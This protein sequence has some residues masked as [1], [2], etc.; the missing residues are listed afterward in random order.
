VDLLNL[1]IFLMSILLDMY[2]HNTREHS[3]GLFL[4][5]CPFYHSH[6]PG[7]SS[8]A[9]SSCQFLTHCDIIANHDWLVPMYRH[10]P[11]PAPSGLHKH[12]WH[13][14]TGKKI[15]ILFQVPQILKSNFAKVNWY[16]ISDDFL[17]THM[18]LL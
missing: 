12:V 15:P 9:L 14:F 13:L 11:G 6:W 18:S 8:S 1:P 5:C 17:K 7:S 2:A 16:K 4:L 10:F 3:S